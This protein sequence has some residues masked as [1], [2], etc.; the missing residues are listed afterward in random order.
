MFLYKLQSEFKICF[1]K[2]FGVGGVKVQDQ[3]KA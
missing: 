1:S 3:S 2:K